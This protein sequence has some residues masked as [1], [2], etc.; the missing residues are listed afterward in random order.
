MFYI[1]DPVRALSDEKGK[2][3]YADILPIASI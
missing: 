2:V 3:I 1:P